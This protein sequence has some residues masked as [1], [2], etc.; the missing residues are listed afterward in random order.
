MASQDFGV[1]LGLAYQGFV[2]RLHAHLAAR[3]F[4]RLGSAHGYVVRTI[5]ARPG[6]T[7]RELAASLG[8]TPQAA[9]KV[10]DTMVRGRFLTRTPDPDDAR[11][12]RLTLGPRGVALL[13]AARAFHAQYE[14]A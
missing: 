5:A 7:Q 12:R 3:G 9:G 8:V 14:R 4:R 2:D 11:A 6:L 1:L 13:A 10:I